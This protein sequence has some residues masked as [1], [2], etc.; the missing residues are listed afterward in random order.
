MTLNHE[1][2]RIADANPPQKLSSFSGAQ[3][4][5]KKLMHVCGDNSCV[6]VSFQSSH[7]GQISKSSTVYCNTPI[8][9]SSDPLF[10]GV[11]NK[12]TLSLGTIQ[13]IHVYRNVINTHHEMRDKH[14]FLSNS[15][16]DS[17]EME[18]YSRKILVNTYI[19]DFSSRDRTG[20]DMQVGG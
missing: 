18:E 10:T 20:T 1:K 5:L 8:V 2:C 12:D 19:S 3:Q 15:Y 13:K 9:V 6:Y 7:L 11:F 17:E 4:A 14:P 16:A